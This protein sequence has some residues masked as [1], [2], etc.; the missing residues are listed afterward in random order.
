MINLGR[1]SW[2][3]RPMLMAAI[4][5]ELAVLQMLARMSRGRSRSPVA[6]DIRDHPTQDHVS[7]VV[8]AAIK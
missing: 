2:C 6:G 1:L 4:G 8:Q 7:V 5:V 3:Y